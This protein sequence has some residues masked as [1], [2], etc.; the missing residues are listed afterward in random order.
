M[1]TCTNE[2]LSRSTDPRAQ[3][4]E[5]SFTWVQHALLA[6]I[7]G[8]LELRGSSR[9]H[10]VNDMLDELAS[11]LGSSAARMWALATSLTSIYR[12]GTSISDS[13]IGFP[14]RT[15]YTPA[16]VS[17][18]SDVHSAPLYVSH[19]LVVFQGLSYSSKQVCE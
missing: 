15:F 9:Q 5:V 19:G 2:V 1:L 8:P 10:S 13:L 11:A 17:L 12:P 6:G 3:I 4:P 18:H 16:D 7:D 14:C